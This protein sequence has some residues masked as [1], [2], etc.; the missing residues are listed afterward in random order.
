M[1]TIKWK[2]QDRFIS[3]WIFLIIWKTVVLLPIVTAISNKILNLRGKKKKLLSE[4][5]KNKKREKI[6]PIL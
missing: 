3:L 2:F 6:K 5:M 1:Y 4:E